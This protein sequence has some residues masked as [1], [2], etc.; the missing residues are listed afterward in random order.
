[1]TPMDLPISSATSQPRPSRRF[2]PRTAAGVGGRRRWISA[3]SLAALRVLISAVATGLIV[4]HLELLLLLIRQVL[5]SSATLGVLQ[6]NGHFFWMIPVA[7]LSVFALLGFALSVA[8][9]FWPRRVSRFAQY[10]WLPLALLVLLCTIPGLHP[11]AAALLAVGSGYRLILWTRSRVSVRRVRKGLRRCL[12]GLSLSTLAMFVWC[13]HQ[14]AS[15]EARGLANLP[16]HRAGAP[17]LVLIVLDTVRADRLSLYGASR[18]TTPQLAR[19]S[20]RGL[21]FE[22]ARSTAP[23]TLPAHASLFTGRLPSDLQVSTRSPLDGKFQT[24][25]EVL[26]EQGYLTAGFV[27]NTFFC[28]AWFGLNQGFLHY[29]DFPNR[30][31]ISATEILRNAEVG[32]RLLDLT[33]RATDIRSGKHASRESGAEVNASALDWLDL[34]TE[35]QPDRPF[36]LFLNYMDAHDPYVLPAGAEHRFG[37]KA[38]TSADQAMLQNWHALKHRQL[39]RRQVQLASDAYDNCL[40]A[41]DQS[42]GELLEILDQRGCLEN[43]WVVITA[44]HGE[45]FGEHGLFLHGDSLYRTAID[46]PLVI[47]PPRGSSLEGKRIA[48]PVSLR[49]VAATLL[50]VSRGSAAKEAGPDDAPPLPGRSL[51]RLW[52][53]AET[54]DARTPLAELGMEAPV[55]EAGLDVKPPRTTPSRLVAPVQLGPMV[56]LVDEGFTYIRR[57]DGAEELFDLVGDPAESNNLADRPEHQALLERFRARAK[58]PR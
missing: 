11:L 12:L 51:A 21:V 54:L 33:S 10:L 46:V 24:L 17:N 32:K 18:D 52:N 14:I 26:R 40:S 31:E 27:A 29:K 44:D 45:Q 7:N 19:W 6:L 43:A 50:D 37:L 13:F 39:D 2:L 28:N 42:I 49:D 20:R 16:T 15:A 1:M 30:N 57:G 56:S 35:T 5:V 58:S 23:W 47:L 22:H 9:W 4:G 38:E 34:Q 53:R 25:A 8:A 55:S 48:A 41:L 3:S 36:F